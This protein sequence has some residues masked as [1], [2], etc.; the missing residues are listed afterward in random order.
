[1]S[2]PDPA[3]HSLLVVI[4]PAARSADGESVR[5]ARD[6]LCAGAR[7]K[8]CLPEGPEEVARALARRGSRRPVVVGDDRALLRVVEL[9]HRERD[10]AG[11]PLSVVPVGGPAA[12]AL[13]RSLGVPTGAVAAAR[14]VLDG[15]GCR[16]DLLVDDLGGVVLGSLAIPSGPTGLYGPSCGPYE[17]VYADPYAPPYPDVP[18]DD[19]AQGTG[20]YGGGY[21]GG[22]RGLGGPDAGRGAAGP[23]RSRPWWSPAARTA[24]SA[25]AW[26][27]GRPGTARPRAARRR[28]LPPAQ[29]LRVEADGVLLADLDRPVDRVSVSTAAP[30]APAP[31]TAPEP[32]APDGAPGQTA[33]AGLAEVVVHARSAQQPVRARARAITVSGP[34]FRYRADVLVG[35]PVPSRTW[36]VLPEAWCLTL[37]R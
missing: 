4:D 7:V 25:L 15:A 12:V 22:P 33:C 35:G 26:L 34:D 5:I 14:A 17:P 30:S 29:R 13:A 32:P 37:P 6:V 3:G 28:D 19:A 10:L 9:L 21:D 8:L 24:R 2:A 16:R 18:Y 1:M 11:A 31:E 23:D 36:T 20:G 27:G